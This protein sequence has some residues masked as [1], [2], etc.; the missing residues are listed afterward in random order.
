MVVQILME[1]GLKK[2]RQEAYFDPLSLFF[3][4]VNH[5]VPVNYLL[6]VIFASQPQSLRSQSFILLP[7]LNEGKNPSQL[8]PLDRILT[9]LGHSCACYSSS[10]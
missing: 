2:M 7:V 3:T 5:P 9:L 1:Q 6:F 8:L 4:L 10:A